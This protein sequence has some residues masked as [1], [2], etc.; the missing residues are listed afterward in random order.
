LGIYLNFQ[1]QKSHI[2]QCLP[3]SES[4]KSY[5]INSVK[6][7]SSSK[8]FPKTP[9]GTFQF[10]WNF[11][12]RC[13]SISSEKIIQY[14]RTSTPQVQTPWNQA[15]APLLLEKLSKE[16]ENSTWSIPVWWIS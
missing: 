4:N 15:D 16:T 11:Q 3:H 9:K 5:Q 10:L 13:N 1:Q 8:I 7:C 6:S 12:L 14:S 2:N